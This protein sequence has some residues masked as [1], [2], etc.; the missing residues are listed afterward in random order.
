MARP[1]Q[2]LSII[3]RGGIVGVVLVEIAGIWTFVTQTGNRYL[4]RAVL[5][6]AMLLVAVLIGAAIAIEAVRHGHGMRDDPD[7]VKRED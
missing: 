5:F 3:T 7:D 2:R 6:A 1:E 4:D